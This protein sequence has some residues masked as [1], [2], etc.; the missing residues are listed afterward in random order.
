[1]DREHGAAEAVRFIRELDFNPSTFSFEDVSQTRLTAKIVNAI[2]LKQKWRARKLSPG[3]WLRLTDPTILDMIADVGYDWVMI[4]A[5]HQA[6][7]LQTLQLLFMALKGSPT[8]PL[9]RVPGQD[10]IYIKQLLDAGAA[11]VLVPHIKNTQRCSSGRGRLQIPPTRHSRCWPTSPGS[12][13]PQSIR[14]LPKRQ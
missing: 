13:R 3:M 9:V 14:V 2:E 5:E 4:D 12:L 6:M 11:G 8:L 10:P 7:D 1:M